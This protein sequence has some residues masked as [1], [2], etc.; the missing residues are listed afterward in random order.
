M[1]GASRLVPRCARDRRR[2]ATASCAADGVRGLSNPNAGSH[3]HRLARQSKKATQGWPSCFDWWRRRES[4]PRP[5]ALR[6]KI[7]VRI[8]PIDLAAC[9]PA[10]GENMKPAQER[11]SRIGPQ[12]TETA[13]L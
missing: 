12:H 10:G 2:R 4:N 13:I 7:Y 3:P 11:F 6:Y 5:Q 8:Q 9:Y 1:L